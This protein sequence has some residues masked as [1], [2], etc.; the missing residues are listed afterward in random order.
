LLKEVGEGTYSHSA[1]IPSGIQT[2]LNR[3]NRLKAKEITMPAEVRISCINKSDRYN[4]HERI[5]NVGG[6]NAG[7]TRWKLSES[8][9]ISDIKQGKWSFY[10]E[11]PAG[12]RVAVIIAISRYGNEY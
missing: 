7:G 12:H 2:Y 10:V 5:L 4:P 1:R 11:R 9:A 6:V 8:Q 3:P